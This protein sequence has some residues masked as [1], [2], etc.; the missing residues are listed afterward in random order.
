MP[1]EVPETEVWPELS[2]QLGSDA[3]GIDGHQRRWL[4]IAMLHRSALYEDVE[5]ADGATYSSHVAPFV[6]LIR[7]LAGQHGREEGSA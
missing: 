2:A 3:D 5:L 1:I 6:S 4:T 7:G